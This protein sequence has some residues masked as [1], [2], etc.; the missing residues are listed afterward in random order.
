V[1]LAS[2]GVSANAHLSARGLRELCVL[3]PGA[4]RVLDQAYDTMRLSA[5]ACDR[6]TKVA[7]TIADLEGSD[8]IQ[9]RHV[10]ES[11][12]YRE[13]SWIRR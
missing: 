12:S 4:T 2:A 10:A 5:R 1:R 8:T 13:Q 3:E 9:R 7:Q 11:L 6:V